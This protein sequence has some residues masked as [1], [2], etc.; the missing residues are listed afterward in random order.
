MYVKKLSPSEVNRKRM[1]QHRTIL[2]GSRTIQ[3]FID[4]LR[5]K[6]A[7]VT[8]DGYQLVEVLKVANGAYFC[9]SQ[10]SIWNNQMAAR[11]LINQ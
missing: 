8:Y 2:F 9:D 10:V 5:G 11:K 3:E 4:P 1:S 7:T 6:N